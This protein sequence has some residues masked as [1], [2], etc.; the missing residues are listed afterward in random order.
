MKIRFPFLS[1]KPQVSL[2]AAERKRRQPAKSPSIPCMR[3]LD[4][5][6]QQKLSFKRKGTNASVVLELARLDVARENLALEVFLVAVPE[7]GCFAVE[8]GGAGRRSCVSEKY[9]KST[10]VTRQVS[11]LF[12]PSSEV[13]FG[14]PRQ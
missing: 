13:E 11:G 3:L 8:G 6:K 4:V 2:E 1:L 7:E 12:L 5:H 14:E 10:G 9:E